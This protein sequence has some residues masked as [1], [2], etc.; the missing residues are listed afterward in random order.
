MRSAHNLG[1]PPCY[2]HGREVVEGV[3]ERTGGVPLFVEEVTRLLLE[4][5]EQ[6]GLQAIPPTLQ[7]SLAARLDRLGE[8]REVAQIGAVL[9][10][11][12]SYALL[13]AVAAVDDRGPTALA[14]RGY[15]DPALQSALDRLAEADLL[16]VE[17]AGSQATYRFKH[18]LIQ[19]A[20]YESL[21]KSRR[22][23]L[24]RRAAEILR[25]EPERAE[26]EPE[27]VAHHFTEAGLDDLAIEWWGR[28]GDRALRRS[29]FQEAIAHLGKA[30]A[31]AD[32]AEGEK[33]AGV[34]GQRG[35]LQ[36]AYANALMAGRGFGA[37]ETREAFVKA[38]QSA[39]QWE[40]A[41]ELFAAD[42]G[43]YASSYVLGDL[44]SLRTHAAALLRDVEAS[45]D[46]PQACV[47]HR[48]NGITHWFAGEYTEAR[49][50]LERALAL[51]RPGRDDDLVLRF[52]FDAG[53]AAMHYLALVL[54][55]LGDVMRAASLVESAQTRTR[56]HHAR[57]HARLRKILCGRARAYS[58]RPF[59]RRAAR[60]RAG[61]SGARPRP[62][63]LACRGS[64]PRRLDDG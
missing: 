47:A 15:R 20:A 5:G 44:P 61:A 45:P 7:Q 55:P 38:R 58:A 56:R 40:D 16:F 37:P 49:D 26:A 63:L 31:M 3:S 34:P 13:R 28:A 22:Q 54:W 52:G 53:V 14:E 19:D 1:N 64:I 50:H 4:R 24:H 29:A 33:A 25:D 12:F 6:G 30:I 18:A 41:I 11:D 36:V 46:S 10:R 39:I 51:F 8:A 43:L 2:F 59:A 17:G 35:Q 57:P 42:F 32:K 48:A 62:A 9:G 21:L 60:L 27:L 23:A